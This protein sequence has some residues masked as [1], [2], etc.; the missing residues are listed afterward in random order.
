[1]GVAEAVAGSEKSHPI[2]T[3]EEVGVVAGTQPAEYR[4]IAFRHC[5]TSKKPTT[6]LTA[7]TTRYD[8]GDAE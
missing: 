5:F 3:V 4:N 2:Q 7:D 8:K 1:M 6:T